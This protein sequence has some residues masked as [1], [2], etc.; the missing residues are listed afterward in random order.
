MLKIAVLSHTHTHFTEF[1]TWHG[2]ASRR[3]PRPGGGA[4]EV[5]CKFIVATTRE[6]VKCCEVRRMAH[7][8]RVA[9]RGV[10]RDGM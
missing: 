5:S 8:L 9:R 2:A 3:W 4:R 6:K 7:S 1:R 10:P